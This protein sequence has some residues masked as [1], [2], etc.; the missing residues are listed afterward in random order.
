MSCSE[1]CCNMEKRQ[2]IVRCRFNFGNNVVFAFWTRSLLGFRVVWRIFVC[3]FGGGE[4]VYICMSRH[5]WFH[6]C[7]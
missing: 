2:R 5:V 3:G 6:K 1:F 4:G 7:K